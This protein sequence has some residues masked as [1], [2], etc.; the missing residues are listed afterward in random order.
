MRSKGKEKLDGEFQCAGEE[1][2]ARPRKVR[3]I[4]CEEEE[5]TQEDCQTITM[6]SK[7]MRKSDASCPEA[8]SG[9]SQASRIIIRIPAQV[10]KGKIIKAITLDLKLKLQSRVF[11]QLTKYLLPRRA[12]LYVNTEDQGTAVKVVR[13]LRCKG[14]QVAQS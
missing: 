13:H 11:R 4:I 2:Q 10:L 1:L 14:G 7:M 12:P 6:N 5:S 9:T 8:S 3:R